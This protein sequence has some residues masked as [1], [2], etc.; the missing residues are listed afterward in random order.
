MPVDRVERQIR[1][2]IDRGEFDALPGAGKPLDDVDR[3]YDPGWWAKRWVERAHREDA[4]AELRLRIRSEV[5]RLKVALDR[6]DAKRRIAELNALI[7]EANEYL[8]KAE[9][10]PPITW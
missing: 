9:R 4:V 1:E 3:Q 6:D 8:G 5:P 10:I 2:A 7:A